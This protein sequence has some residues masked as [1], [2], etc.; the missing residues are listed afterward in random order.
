LLNHYKDKGI[1]EGY[2]YPDTGIY[3]LKSIIFCKSSIKKFELALV[4]FTWKPSK[5]FETVSFFR[6]SKKILP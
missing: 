4:R 3:Y 2:I 5:K 1:K 6:E